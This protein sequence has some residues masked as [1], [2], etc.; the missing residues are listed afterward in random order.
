MCTNVPV[1]VLTANAEGKSKEMYAGEGF[2]GQLVK[3]ISGRALEEALLDYLPKE[4]L[5]TSGL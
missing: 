5:I 4:K 3:P 1:I 2:D